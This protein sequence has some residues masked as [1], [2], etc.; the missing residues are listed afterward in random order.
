M[1]ILGDDDEIN[2]S[3]LASLQA[4]TDAEFELARRMHGLNRRQQ[5]LLI[6]TPGFVALLPAEARHLVSIMASTHVQA[7][8]GDWAVVQFA[9]ALH[10]LHTD[11]KDISEYSELIARCGSEM[12]ML[13]AHLK[14]MVRSNA[15]SEK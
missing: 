7:F 11:T 1:G 6:S 9:M 3:A 5:K 4:C 13:E 8:V 10:S 2:D 15:D 14:T 12:D